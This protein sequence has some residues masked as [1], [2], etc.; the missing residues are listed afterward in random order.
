MEIFLHVTRPQRRPL[1]MCRAT[2]R[3]GLRP[4]VAKMEVARRVRVPPRWMKR[5]PGW[6]KTCS[7]A[8]SSAPDLAGFQLR[9]GHRDLAPHTHRSGARALC[10]VSGDDGES[11]QGRIGVRVVDAG[12]VD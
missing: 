2:Q 10:L 7:G 1:T 6:L 12:L 4:L 9:E 5:T 3:A 11:C 8:P